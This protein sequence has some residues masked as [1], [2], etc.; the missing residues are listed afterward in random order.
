MNIKEL[1]NRLES[2]YGPRHWESRQDALSVLIETIL[3]QNTSDTNSHRAFNSLLATFGNWETVAHANAE[4]IAHSIEQGG[5]SKIKA[6]RIKNVLEHIHQERGDYS[7]D[8]LA[9]LSLPE[10]KM[11]LRKMPGVGP[12]TAGCVLLF[13]L[14]MPAMPVDTH[15]FRVTKRLGLIGSR[16]PVDQAHDILE[17]LILPEKVYSCHLHLIEHGRRVCR[18]QNPRCHQCMLVEICAYQISQATPSESTKSQDIKISQ[19][20]TG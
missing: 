8:F 4:D 12:K 3:S 9:C 15:V 1:L 16:I 14:G 6:Q 13:G 20:P 10:A 2:E 17:S 11:W 7:I 5:L 18:A 19:S